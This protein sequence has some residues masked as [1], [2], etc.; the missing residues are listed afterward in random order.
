R[1]DGAKPI[2]STTQAATAACHPLATN[3]TKHCEHSLNPT[4]RKTISSLELT[5]KALYSDALGG[6]MVFMPHHRRIAQALTEVVQGKIK[7]LI[8]NMPPRAGKTLL[9]SQMFPAWSMGLNPRAQFILTSYSK[10]LASHNTYAIREIIRS[11]MYQHLFGANGATVRDDS[12][13]RDMFRTTAGGQMYAVSTGGTITGSGAGSMTDHAGSSGAII[14][15]DPAKPDAAQS[16]TERRNVIEWY[17]QTLQSRV[18]H[19]D[20]PIILVSQRLHENDLPGWLL[21]G[22]TGENWELVKVPAI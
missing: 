20:T 16:D 5:S 2:T 8:I 17:Q 14:I 18:N 13:A 4:I 7:R 3:T 19:P 11:G 10:T 1:R 22:G 12:S 15:D 21:S 9:I 6:Q